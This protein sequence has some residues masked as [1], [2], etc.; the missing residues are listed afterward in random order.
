LFLQTRISLHDPEYHDFTEMTKSGGA[1]DA[2][3]K[4]RD[5]G[6]IRAH[7]LAGGPV[8]EMSR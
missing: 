6:E 5:E 2:L 3:N 4:M 8:Q 7:R 1:V